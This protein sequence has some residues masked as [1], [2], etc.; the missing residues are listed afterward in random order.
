MISTVIFNHVG[1]IDMRFAIYFFTAEK[2]R[3][4]RL[5]VLESAERFRITINVPTLIASNHIFRINKIK[6]LDM[7]SM[8]IFNPYSKQR[9]EATHFNS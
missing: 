4:Y 9:F 8:V 7:I 2:Q 1:N 5:G 6:L 3:K